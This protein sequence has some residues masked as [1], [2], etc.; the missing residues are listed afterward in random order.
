METAI[1]SFTCGVV[2]AGLASL[3]AAYNLIKKWESTC[4]G[5][6]EIAFKYK[7]MYFQQLEQ[8]TLLEGRKNPDLY[9]PLH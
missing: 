6:K 9:P 4:D 5:W 3:W 7:D 1:I 2:I 8:N